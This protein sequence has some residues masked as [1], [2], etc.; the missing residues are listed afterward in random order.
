MQL[1]ITIE[2]GGK[3]SAILHAVLNYIL[4]LREKL[5]AKLDI[6]SMR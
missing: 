6:I 3:K 4:S 2:I 1:K 5:P